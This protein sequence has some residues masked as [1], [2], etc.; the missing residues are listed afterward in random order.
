L[1][2]GMNM[3]EELDRNTLDRI[4][5]RL[6]RRFVEQLRKIPDASDPDDL[7]QEALADV[8][9]GR[10]KYPGEDVTLSVC[11]FNIVRS[12]VD[13][14]QKKRKRAQERARKETHYYGTRQNT[15][16]M[17]AKIEFINFKQ[18]QNSVADV[19]SPVKAPSLRKEILTLVAD[20]PLLVQI[21]RVQMDAMV[22][23]GKKLRATELAERLNIAV[24]EIYNANRRLKARLAKIR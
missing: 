23:P 17:G 16:I 20:D 18:A 4:R 5:L 12:K 14:I 6:W 9:S 19:L 11:L 7:L 22:N 10:R 24:A 1:L 2:R 3:F 8:L 15:D 21:V 13:N